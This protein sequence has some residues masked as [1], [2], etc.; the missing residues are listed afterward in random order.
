MSD[1]DS[2]YF[3]FI[4]IIFFIIFLSFRIFAPELPHCNIWHIH[5]YSIQ[6]VCALGPSWPTIKLLFWQSK[7]KSLGMSA[8]ESVYTVHKDG[9]EVIHKHFRVYKI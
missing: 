8:L 5:V 9:T 4:I 2:Q 6:Y 1:L 3:F 7:V